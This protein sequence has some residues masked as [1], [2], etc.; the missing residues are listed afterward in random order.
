M[1]RYKITTKSGS[2]YTLEIVY[3]KV[4][5]ISRLLRAKPKNQ[6]VFMQIRDSK[7]GMLKEPRLLR[8]MWVSFAYN[9]EAVD[10]KNLTEK[11]IYDATY[12]HYISG[13]NNIG[14]TAIITLVEKI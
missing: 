1:A 9:C 7:E 5:F 6:I 14:R 13:D 2:V 12:I 8:F 10:E 3:S 11:D 4:S